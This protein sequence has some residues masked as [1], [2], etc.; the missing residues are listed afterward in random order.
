MTSHPVTCTKAPRPAARSAVR[1]WPQEYSSIHSLPDQGNCGAAGEPCAL[2]VPA[3]EHL[4]AA[5]PVRPVLGVARWAGPGGVVVS[6][7]AI[8]G[9]VSGII[10][11]SGGSLAGPDWRGCLGIG[12]VAQRGSGDGT[13]RQRGHDQD[14]VTG[15]CVI[16]PELG[17]VQ[18]QVV[19]AQFKAF[20][21]WPAQPGGADQPGL[22]HR[23][24]LRHVA[25]VKGQLAAAEVAADQQVV[26]RGGGGQPCPG[27]PALALGAGPGRADL[28]TAVSLSRRGTACA[29]LSVTPRASVR[30]KVDGIRS[31]YP[32]RRSSQNW[33]N[34]VQLP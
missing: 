13:C 25:V 34:W 26:P 1:G 4:V 10:P 21:G 33:R 20:F 15:D 18:A 23:L 22:A 12:A 5:P 19:L 9:M 27:I 14:G 8:S 28:P 7:R 31:T 30:R 2:V 6:R 32:W 3:G 17:F 24:A 16:E 29:Q 11:G